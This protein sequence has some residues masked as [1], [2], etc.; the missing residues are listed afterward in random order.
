MLSECTYE[1]GHSYAHWVRDTDCNTS[2][3]QL[4]KLFLCLSITLSPTSC[5]KIVQTCIEIGY[6]IALKNH[7]GGE[8]SATWSTAVPR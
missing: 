6:A 4:R 5:F 1:L 3:M 7:R 2:A 8:S